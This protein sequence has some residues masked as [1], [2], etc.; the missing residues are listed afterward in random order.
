MSVFSVTATSDG[1]VVSIKVT[2][3]SS[4][5]TTFNW[6]RETVRSRIGGTTVEDDGS[7]AFASLTNADTF[8]IPVGKAYVYLGG[9]NYWDV[10]IDF[11]SLVGTNVTFDSAGIGPQSPA[12]GN[13]DSW[14]GATL[15]VTIVSGNFTTRSDFDKITYGY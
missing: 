6:I 7:H 2:P 15:I 14:D 8:Q 10:L 11:N 13:V 12:V 1:S 4:G 9:Y 5:S 3:T